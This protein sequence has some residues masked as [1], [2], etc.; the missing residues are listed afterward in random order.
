MKKFAN[1]YLDELKPSTDKLTLRFFASIAG[2][3]L[4]I[5]LL[6]SLALTLISGQQKDDFVASV[7]QANQL[8]N[9]L[10]QRQTLLQQALNDSTLNEELD[11]LQQQLMLRQRLWGQ[12]KT[13][14]GR[15]SVDFSQLLVDLSAADKA[16]IWLHRIVIENDALTLKGQT[17]KPQLLPAWLADFSRYQTLKDRPFGV[18]ELRDEGARGLYFT[19]GH[20]HHSSTSNVNAGGGYQ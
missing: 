3:L 17:L 8:E 1:L 7:E 11:T 20:L 9:Q 16:D 12:M 15:N 14:T 13:L 6:A 10:R 4:L 2:S 19:V 5:V 18:F